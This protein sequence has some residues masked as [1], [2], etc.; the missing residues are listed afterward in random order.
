LVYNIFSMTQLCMAQVYIMYAWLW[1][2]DMA[3]YYKIALLMCLPPYMFGM[4]ILRIEQSQY[5]DSDTDCSEDPEKV[6]FDIFISKVE[7]TMKD[8]ETRVLHGLQL[9]PFI[10]IEG[11]F[12]ISSIEGHFPE[13]AYINMHYVKSADSNTYSEIIRVIDTQKRVDVF[14]KESCRMGITL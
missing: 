5:D 14:N 13:L 1:L 6:A 12:Y 11:R 3:G 4:P 2:V 10:N 9:T 8:G 7:L